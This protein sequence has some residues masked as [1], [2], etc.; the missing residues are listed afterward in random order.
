[1]NFR[2]ATRSFP[3]IP[4]GCR[5][6][7]EVEAVKEPEVCPFCVTSTLFPDLVSRIVPDCSAH[8]LHLYS[9]SSHW[10]SPLLPVLECK[11]IQHSDMPFMFPDQ[12]YRVIASIVGVSIILRSTDVCRYNLDASVLASGSIDHIGMFRGVLW[13]LRRSGA[14]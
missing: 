10:C 2:I 8:R 6:T 3:L 12:P 4:L 9:P 11:L 5:L 7:L 14:C 13:W 1:L